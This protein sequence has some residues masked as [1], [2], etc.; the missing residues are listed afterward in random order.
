MNKLFLATLLAWVSGTASVEAKDV[1]TI[2]VADDSAREFALGD[3]QFKR[4]VYEDFGYEDTYF[5]VNH[6]V[7]SASF[8]AVLPGPADIWGG[9]G[10]TS[11]L[12]THDINILFGL[13]GRVGREPWSLVLDILDCHPSNPPLLSVT[14]NGHALTIPLKAGSKERSLEEDIDNPR[15][16]LVSVSLDG[17]LREGAM[18]ST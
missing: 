1:F 17:W 4:F 2:G 3:N 9:T 12:R 18:L 16:Q 6:S 5:L 14:V 8:P 10:G 15:E 13:S 11:G 7:L